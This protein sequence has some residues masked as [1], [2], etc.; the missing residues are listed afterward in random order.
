MT[1][2]EREYS[3]STK[4]A[5]IDAELDRYRTTADEAARLPHEVVRTAGLAGGSALVVMPSA[6]AHLHIFIHG[7]Y[8]QELRARDSIG[9]ALGLVDAT[10]AF[11]AIDYT[12]APAATIATM[13][14]QCVD[15]FDALLTRYTPRSVTLSG[16]SAGAHLAAHVALRRPGRIGHLILLSGVYDLVPL[17]QTYVNE[18]LALTESSARAL[19][20]PLDHRPDTAVL[21]VHGQHETD[22]FI[23]QSAAL[24]EAWAAPRQALA[25]RNHFDVVFELAAFEHPSRRAV[26]LPH[27]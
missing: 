3:P 18:P 14:H 2:L 9:P 24:A 27:R 12:L 20:V 17:I 16:H 7:G 13:I 25:G 19:S 21:V 5:S 26:Q 23:A 22:A 1:P 4:V 11:A 8:W 10:T 6:G 15:T